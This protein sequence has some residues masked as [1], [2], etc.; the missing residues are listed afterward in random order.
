MSACHV[1]QYVACLDLVL[2]VLRCFWQVTCNHSVC[3][4]AHE[5]PDSLHRILSSLMHDLYELELI[6]CH[7]QLQ[8]QI[9]CLP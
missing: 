6:I 9:Q 8:L 5:C 4:L 7:V 3:D 2:H 1:V